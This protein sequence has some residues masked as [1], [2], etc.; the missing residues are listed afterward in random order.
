M[1]LVKAVE[2][3][4]KKTGQA[5]RIVWGGHLTACA[6]LLVPLCVLAQS[7]AGILTDPMRPADASPA[8]AHAGTAA[9]QASGGP[10]VILISPQRKLAVI[11]GAV[12]PLGAA[13][14]EGTL[15]G[16]TDSA[17]VLSKDGVRDVLL[18]HPK[19]DKRPTSSPKRSQP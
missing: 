7:S 11:D 10:Q 6:T 9:P 1:G 13:T 18:M 4:N 2:E 3:G 8:P 5:R 19:V 12:V 17:A 15:V 16:L 14:R